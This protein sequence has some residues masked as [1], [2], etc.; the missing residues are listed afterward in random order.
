MTPVSTA[1]MP[2]SMAAMIRVFSEHKS[3]AV[4]QTLFA[5]GAAA[6]EACDSVVSIDLAIPAGIGWGGD[7]YQ[8]LRD[9][10]G[11]LALALHTAWDS[12]NDAQ[13]SVL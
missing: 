12:P 6:L 3:L 2:F 11:R 5:M 1:R 4:Q 7:R 9:K 10:Q 13:G 8:V